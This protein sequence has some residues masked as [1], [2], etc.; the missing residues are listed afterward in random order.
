[1]TPQ[2][3]LALSQFNAKGGTLTHQMMLQLLIPLGQ[4]QQ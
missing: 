1:M 2:H 3:P 4:R